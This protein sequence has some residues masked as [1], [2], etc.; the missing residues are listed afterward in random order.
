MIL[1]DLIRSS[2]RA[3]G[4]MKMGQ[5]F[6]AD[7]QIDGLF[8]LNAMLEAWSIERLNVFT[9]QPQIINLNASQQS[10]QWGTGAADINAPRPLRLERVNVVT[11]AT[12]GPLELGLE[13][14]TVLQWAAIPIKS[15]PS[16]LPTRCYL[17]NQFP[18]AG[19]FVWPVPSVNL[20]LNAY[21]WQ[22]ITTGFTS[23]TTTVSFPPGYAEAIRYNLAVKI[24]AECEGAKVSDFTASEAVRT[25]AAI[26]RM[27]KPRLYLNCD[28]AM[29]SPN[30]GIWNWLTGTT[31]NN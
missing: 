14:L 9:V 2:F 30:G 12:G 10:Y 29:T 25:K 18:N 7:E 27:N 19:F 15:T 5:V 17:D 23:V 24:A 31:Q 16:T 6:N 26:K 21:V 8:I 3:A 13:I 4:L 22:A 28:A 1:Q 20:Q 11:P